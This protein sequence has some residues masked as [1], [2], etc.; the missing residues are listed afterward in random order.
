[1]HLWQIPF[2][3][4]RQECSYEQGDAKKLNLMN[5]YV[6]NRNMKLRNFVVKLKL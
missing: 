3:I 1:M 4:L 6:L 2:G 5:L